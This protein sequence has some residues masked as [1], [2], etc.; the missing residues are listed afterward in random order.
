MDKSSYDP[1]RTPEQSIYEYILHSVCVS[2]LAGIVAE[3]LGF[4]DAFRK[5]MELAGLLHD[6]GKGRSGELDFSGSGEDG[7]AKLDIDALRS[8]RTHPSLGYMILKEEGYSNFVANAVLYHHENYDGTGFP[9]NLR[10]KEIPVAARI[11][12]VCDTYAALITNR[13]YRRAFDPDTAMELMREDVKYFDMKVFL[14]F[15]TVMQEEK[16]QKLITRIIQSE[17][18]L[19]DLAWEQNIEMKEIDLLWQNLCRD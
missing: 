4:E 11:L 13:P 17:S 14:A 6:I 3:E 8:S 19:E 7:L 5:D 16:N 9:S 15:L 12:R 2:R 18:T 1:K 10:G